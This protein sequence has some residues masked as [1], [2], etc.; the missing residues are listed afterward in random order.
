M[1]PDPVKNCHMLYCSPSLVGRRIG[2]GVIQSIESG[3]SLCDAEFVL[4]KD[5]S[6]GRKTSL[7]VLKQYNKLAGMMR[8]SG[9]L[10]EWFRW[11]FGISQADGYLQP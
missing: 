9:L 1:P 11:E 8:R 4:W 5:F 6:S 2:G 7:C 3:V 10:I